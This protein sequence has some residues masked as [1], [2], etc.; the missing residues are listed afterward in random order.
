[1]HITTKHH[2]NEVQKNIFC[3]IWQCTTDFCINCNTLIIVLLELQSV[4]LQVLLILHNLPVTSWRVKQTRETQTDVKH[5]VPAV[6]Q[7][8]QLTVIKSTIGSA[9]DL[10]SETPNQLSKLP[11]ALCFP[12][13]EIKRT[14]WSIAHYSSS[15]HLMMPVILWAGDDIIVWLV[16]MWGSLKC[17]WCVCVCVCGG[18]LI[19]ESRICLPEGGTSKGPTIQPCTK[20]ER[21]TQRNGERELDVLK[22]SG[23]S[24]TDPVLDWA[25]VHSHKW[26]S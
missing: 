3:D 16:S 12:L 14:L 6:K 24:E 9:E 19:G 5:S 15:L 26:I 13:S 7:H 20:S 25:F 22:Q 21:E 8:K 1:M 11:P 4:T 18:A 23:R 2:L 17:E 10:V